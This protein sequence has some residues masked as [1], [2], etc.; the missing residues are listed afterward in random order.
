MAPAPSQSELTALLNRIIRRITRQLTR[1]GLL[2][3]E[4]DQSYLDLQADD[5]L[6][7]FGAASLQYR[8]VLGPNAGSR[9]LSLRNPVGTGASVGD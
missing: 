4:A 9:I 7:H 1:D 2:V 8:V 5:T 6:D 3:E